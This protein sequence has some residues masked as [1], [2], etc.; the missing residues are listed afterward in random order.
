MAPKSKQAERNAAKKLEKQGSKI[1]DDEPAT[2]V[3]GPMAL[4]E[5]AKTLVMGSV[6][7]EIAPMMQPLIKDELPDKKTVQEETKA[8][9]GRIGSWL[10]SEVAGV[11]DAVT[12]NDEDG[13]EGEEKKQE[14]N[15]A[16]AVSVTGLFEALQTRLAWHNPLGLAFP[17]TPEESWDAWMKMKDLVRSDAL[18]FGPRSKKRGSPGMERILTNM[19]INMAQYLHILLAMMML[20]CFLFRSY[21]AC[22]PWLVGYQYAS[23]KL[24]L[25]N[26]EV[27]GQ[28]VPLEK[29]PLKFRVV[30]SVAIHGLIWLFFLY[31]AVYKTYFVEK[32]PLVGL[33]VGAAYIVRPVDK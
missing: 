15:P 5:K 1:V 28:E 29:C 16:D 12:G 8:A 4:V 30:G 13:N 20:R 24:P 22:L 11:V 14:A 33:F 9:G 23:L 25:K 21:F 19:H 17:S 7:V 18:D 10:A 2:T 3:E 32:I 26:M 27:M 6:I 31:E